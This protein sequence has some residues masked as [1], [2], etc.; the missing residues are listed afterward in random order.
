[1]VCGVFLIATAKSNTSIVPEPFRAFF[2]DFEPDLTVH[3][4]EYLEGKQREQLRVAIKIEE[5]T[6]DW[7]VTDLWDS[8]REAGGS[9]TH[10][11]AA[12]MGA[13]SGS[14]TAM[15][16]T[17]VSAYGGRYS[18]AVMQRLNELNRKREEGPYRQSDD[19]RT[20]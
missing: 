3:L 6:N 14:G 20:G 2:T 12:M 4:L 9:F 8:L 19:R 11:N 18:Q 1:M 10:S 17:A 16:N 5:D 13:V 7:T 15:T